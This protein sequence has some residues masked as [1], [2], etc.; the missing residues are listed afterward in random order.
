MSIRRLF[1]QKQDTGGGDYPLA[2]IISE[3]KFDNNTL[4][5]VGTNDGTG[6]NITYEAGLVG[7]SIQTSGVGYVAVPDADNLSFT[8]GVNDLPFS[9]S[10][11]IF[12]TVVE[13][14]FLFW[15]GGS[16]ADREYRVSQLN[17]S[18]DFRLMNP[19]TSFLSIEP[20]STSFLTFND[21]NHITITYDGS[22]DGNGVAIYRDGLSVAT[23]VSETGTYTGMVNSTIP[24]TIGARTVTLGQTPFD[25]NMD[26]TRFWNKE[27]TATEVST[28]A[29]AELA[30]TDINP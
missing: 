11:A 21:W 23:T 22:K 8:D 9:I 29:T 18:I 25:G 7:Q 10:F 19:T 17:S 14:T 2:N 1:L 3:W 15:K 24:L 30:G 28:I 27:L 26:C 4:D 16:T 13:N 12:P 20:T 5:T 6:V